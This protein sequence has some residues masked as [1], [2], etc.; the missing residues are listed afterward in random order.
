MAFVETL[1]QWI[2]ADEG[3]IGVVHCKAGMLGCNH[4]LSLLQTNIFWKSQGKGRTGLMISCFLLDIN[5]RTGAQEALEYYGYRR[6]YDGMGVT[7]PSQLRYVAYYEAYRKSTN[8][9]V[10]RE[11][12][13]NEVYMKPL[14][15]IFGLGK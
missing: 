6:T 1:K 3:N 14:P 4:N 5:F 11:V 15:S 13:I 9:Y 7:I 8:L 10:K 12:E 2:G